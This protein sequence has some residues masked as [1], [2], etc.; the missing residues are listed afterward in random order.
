M[1]D[2]IWQRPGFW[3]KCAVFFIL[4]HWAVFFFIRQMSGPPHLVLALFV[5]M[6]FFLIFTLV[7]TLHLPID[8]QA[9]GAVL[10]FLAILV[11]TLIYGS[12]GAL[13]GWAIQRM[14]GKTPGKGPAKGLIEKE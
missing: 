14:F 3:I 10:A 4:L 8:S 12:F 1:R 2:R 13:L 9:G 5:G 11:P 7:H 6:P